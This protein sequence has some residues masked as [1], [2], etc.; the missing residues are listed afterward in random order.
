SCGLGLSIVQ[1]IVLAHQGQVFAQNHPQGGAWLTLYL[2]RS[3]QGSSLSPAPGPGETD[4][5]PGPLS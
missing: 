3:F 2:P 5:P 1:Q 4:R